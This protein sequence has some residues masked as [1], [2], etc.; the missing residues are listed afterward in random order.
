MGEEQTLQ[1]NAITPHCRRD[2]RRL[3]RQFDSRQIFVNR[4]KS[5]L[6]AM[7]GLIVPAA[8]GAGNNFPRAPDS[9]LSLVSVELRVGFRQILGGLS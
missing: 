9:S 4:H 8:A 2:Q 6:S 5:N 1:G 7:L 3:R